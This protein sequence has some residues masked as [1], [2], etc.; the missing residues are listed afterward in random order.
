MSDQD[1]LMTKAEAAQATAIALAKAE[2]AI[3]EAIV[4]NARI[5]A[6][7]TRK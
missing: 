6:L 2:A 1:K 4:V 5:I 3:K 7:T